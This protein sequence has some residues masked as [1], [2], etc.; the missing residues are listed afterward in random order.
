MR[1]IIGMIAV[2]AGV[3]AAGVP[4]AADTFLDDL[5]SSK[6]WTVTVGVT[7][8]AMPAWEGADKT[9]FGAAPVFNVR[10][11]GT[12]ARYFNAREGIGITLFEIGRLQIGPVGQLKWHRRVKDDPA[13]LQG[14]GDVDYAVEIGG[15]AEYWA[16]DWLR[17]RA[18]VRQGFGGHHGIVADQMIDVVLPY[19][20]WTLSAGPRLRIVSAAANS[21][22]YD[23]TFA[24]S[25]ASGLPVYDAGGGVRSVGAGA[26]AIY[27]FN[28]QFAVHG[29]VEYD[30]LVGD[31]ADSPVVRLRG[32]AD[33]FTFGAGFAYSF[34]WVR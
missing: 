2:G 22:Y 16:F 17:Y 33:Q 24:Q 14:L 26:Q 34:D 5:R 23:I 25:L 12:P 3:L 20:P 10:P 18:E 6:G 28:P 29:F 32:D 8:M 30:H 4:A 21:P 1:R 9:I 31:V 13:A 11:V 15:F 7:G 19:G 27:R